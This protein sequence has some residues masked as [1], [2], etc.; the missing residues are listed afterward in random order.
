ME[1]SGAGPAR[2]QLP[3]ARLGRFAPALLGLSDPDHPLPRLRR[4][5]GAGTRIAGQPARGC[6]LRQ[7]RQ[8]A[9]PSSDLEA[10]RLPALRRRGPARNRHLRHLLRIVVVFRPLLLAAAK[11]TAASPRAAADHWLPVDQYIGGIE[12]A[13]LHLL[14]SRFFTR[15]LKTC[16]Y[17]DVE[18]PF[19]GLADPGHDLPRDLS[20][21]RTA[22]GCS[23]TE[24]EKRARRIGGRNRRRPGRSAVG[25]SE[26]MSKSKKNVVDPAGIIATYGADTARLFMLSDS[27]PER[28]LDW[29]ECRHRR[30]FSLCQ[31]PVADGRRCRALPCPPRRRRTGRFRRGGEAGAP[32]DP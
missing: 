21:T 24:V 16:G 9:G 22:N 23:P 15:A 8:S 20:R 30:R 27:P 10:C 11:P 12:H 18:E 7:T 26:K 1:A 5:A 3:P 19:A 25:R 6:D 31:P 14:Y 2:R 28:D 32:A 13:V 17:L 4:G 29:T